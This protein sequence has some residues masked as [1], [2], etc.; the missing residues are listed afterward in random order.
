MKFLI[1]ENELVGIHQPLQAIYPGHTID[2]IVNTPMAGLKDLPLFEAMT[3]AG[4]TALITQDRAQIQ[5]NLDEV[6]AL[7][8][9]GLHWIGRKQN[10][11][12]GRRGMALAAASHVAAMP[13]LLDLME[14]ATEPLM[15]QV[16][17]VPKDNTQ[18]F[19]AETLA[20]CRDRIVRRRESRRPCS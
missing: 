3:E 11:V 4:Y 2:H 20:V 15:L 13:H 1:D 19:K 18:R 12:P 7:L 5:D 10:K 16:I 8:D 14:S 6:Q 17:N 9:H